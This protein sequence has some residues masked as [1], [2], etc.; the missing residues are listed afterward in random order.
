MQYLYIGLAVLAAVAAVVGGYF[1]FE[2]FL[3]G[4]KNCKECKAYGGSCQ[5]KLEDGKPSEYSGCH[6]P[7]TKLE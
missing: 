5:Y 2:K 7:S 1:L 4:I 6:I 3:G